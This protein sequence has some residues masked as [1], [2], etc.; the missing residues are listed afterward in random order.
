[1]PIWCRRSECS[2]QIRRTRVVGDGKLHHSLRDSSPA[3]V[4]SSEFLN[5]VLHRFI[6]LSSQSDTGSVVLSA[7]LANRPS[8]PVRRDRLLCVHRFI[9]TRAQFPFSP[10]RPPHHHSQRSPTKFQY[11]TRFPFFD[12]P[13]QRIMNQIESECR[14]SRGFYSWKGRI[15]AKVQH[16]RSYIDSIAADLS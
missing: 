3:C 15:T 8:S 2:V 13:G 11:D 1:M 9:I 6:L 12:Q 7:C 10:E 4:S 16:M 14:C 5:L